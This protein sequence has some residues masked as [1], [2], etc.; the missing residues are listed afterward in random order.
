MRRAMLVRLREVFESV[1]DTI[2]GRL[3]LSKQHHN[4]SHI[5]RRKQPTAVG[6]AESYSSWAP[7]CRHV[8]LPQLLCGHIW[9]STHH[10]WA[11]ELPSTLGC[12]APSRP[13]EDIAPKQTSFRRNLGMFL[14]SSLRR[15]RGVFVLNRVSHLLKPSM[16][17]T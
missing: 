9:A 2:T 1:V 8:C 15:E 12:L 5:I 14:G 7:M 17:G 11:A 16:H 13:R 6:R 10:V 3:L 4:L